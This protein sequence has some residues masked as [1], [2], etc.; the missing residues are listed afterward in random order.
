M[1]CTLQIRGKDAAGEEGTRR[2]N[3]EQEKELKMTLDGEKIYE[4]VFFAMHVKQHLQCPS[5]LW[6]TMIVYLSF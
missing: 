2:R 4:K 5:L 1:S 3:K 6:Q